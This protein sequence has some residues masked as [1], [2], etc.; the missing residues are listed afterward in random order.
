M[1]WINCQNWTICTFTVFGNHRKSL[2]QHCKQNQF[3]ILSGQKFIE[4]AKN[5]PFWQVIKNLKMRHFW[6]F[7]NTVD[8]DNVNGKP[9]DKS[10]RKQ[11]RLWSFTSALLDKK[12]KF[13]RRLSKMRKCQRENY[14]CDPEENRKKMRSKIG[15]LNSFS[16]TFLA[17]SDCEQKRE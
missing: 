6:W 4:N 3:Y 9:P 11:N 13:Q 2:I 15:Q 7:S 17:F 10:Q 5:G 12:G 16:M 8:F 1:H 14:L